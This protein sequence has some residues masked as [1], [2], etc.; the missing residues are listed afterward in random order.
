[1]SFK[2][3]DQSLDISTKITSVNELIP[4]SGS[5]FSGTND[6]TKR[7]ANITS[8][9]YISGGFWQTTYDGTPS[10][11]SSSALVDF[12]YGHSVSSSIA[13]YTETFINSEKQRVYKQMAGLLLGDE[14][15][16]FSFN[17]TN[18]HELFFV[19]LKRRIYKDEV[20]KGSV[21]LS[22]ILSGADT[23]TLSDTGASSVYTIG[24]S[25][26]EAS[27]YSGSIEVGKVY[28]NVGIVAFHSGVF[29]PG[30]GVHH[31]SGSINID[32]AVVTGSIDNIMDGFRNHINADGIQFQ[33]QTNLH[34]TLYFCR[35]YNQEFNYSAN[36]TFIDSDGRIIPTSGSD[37]QTRSYITT[38]GLYDINDNLLAVAKLSEP[39]KKSPDNELTIRVRLSY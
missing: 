16:L 17:S 3:F 2:E 6:Y 11:I 39:V 23:L 12:T 31:W 4:I 9:S 30:V 5:Y 1:M 25:G 27:L 8:G 7:F 32:Q 18:F 38:V 15:A 28:Y 21:V 34:S 35:A 29:L 13:G 24:P 22:M 19:L 20:K 33:N 36:P 37:N 10:S 14:D 26:D